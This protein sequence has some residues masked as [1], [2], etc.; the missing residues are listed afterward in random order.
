MPATPSDGTNKN[1]KVLKSSIRYNT[2][3]DHLEVSLNHFLYHC[4]L[5]D[6]SVLIGINPSKMFHISD[7]QFKSLWGG[8]FSPSIPGFFICGI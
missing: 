4:F 3:P 7:Q 1:R 6:S 2:D 5:V 8:G